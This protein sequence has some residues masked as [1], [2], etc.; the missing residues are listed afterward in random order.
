MQRYFSNEKENNKLKISSNDIHHIKNVMRMQ[1]G[2]LIEV[3]YNQKLYICEVI[4]GS[5]FVNIKKEIDN[6]NFDIDVTLIIPLLKE[7][8]MDLIMQKATELGVT[9]IIPINTERSII[10][11]DANKFKK[12]QERWQTICKEASEQSKRLTIPIVEDIATNSTLKTLE[13][14]KLVCSTAEKEKNLKFFLQTF[15]KCAK[16]VLVIGPEG[17]FTKQ[18]EDNFVSCGF[19]RVS[20][21]NRIMRVETVPLFLLSIIN[22]ICME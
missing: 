22:Y 7:Q 2:D 11:L 5:E 21:G 18:E 19:E 1:N 12:K 3:V 8:K 9:R 13:G 15:D 6:N 14:V 4:L 20:L 16:L 17:G 10:K